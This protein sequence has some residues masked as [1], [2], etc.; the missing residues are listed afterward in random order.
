M[1]RRQ[2]LGAG[3]RGGVRVH[4]PLAGTL[5]RTQ[6][7]G[8]HVIGGAG[9]VSVPRGPERRRR[10]DKTTWMGTLQ[11]LAMPGLLPL[12]R[13]VLTYHIISPLQPGT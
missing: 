7:R 10:H 1:D 13:G 4:R 2:V 6:H 3:C 5:V 8:S 12:Q 9:G 11:K